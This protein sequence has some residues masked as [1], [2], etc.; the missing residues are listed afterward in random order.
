MLFQVVSTQVVVGDKIPRDTAGVVKTV[1]GRSL[2]IKTEG[3]QLTV[4]AKYRWSWC[5]IFP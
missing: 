2:V 5:L 3:G 1:G 4:C